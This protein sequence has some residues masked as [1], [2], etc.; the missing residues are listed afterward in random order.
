[1]VSSSCS[2]FFFFSFYGHPFLSIFSFLFLI[3]PLLS[4][5]FCW[6]FLCSLYFPF[7]LPI[8]SISSH[9]PLSSN[10]GPLVAVGRYPELTR[11]CLS[12]IHKRI[13]SADTCPWNTKLTNS[14]SFPFFLFF[15]DAKRFWIIKE[16]KTWSY[17][18]YRPVLQEIQH[19]GPLGVTQT[20]RKLESV[21]AVRSCDSV[22]QVRM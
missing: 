11:R 15:D 20:L 9:F 8:L 2:F 4:Y 3:F 21:T 7:L 13:V 16:S 19:G 5:L 6:C 12:R 1:V 10:H 18:M 17:R 22:T 14:S